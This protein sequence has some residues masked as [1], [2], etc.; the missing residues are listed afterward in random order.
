[1]P[2]KNCFIKIS[3]DMLE[4]HEVFDWIKELSQK[5][6][7]VICVGG[8]TQI[9]EEFE[10]R[11]LEINFG[12]LGRECDNFSQKQ[13]ARDILEINKQEVKNTLADLGV[14]ASVII[15]VV[16]VGTVLCHVNGDQFV[17]LAYHGFDAIFVVT[18]QKRVRDKTIFFAPCNKIKVISF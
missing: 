13:L 5:Y 15:P 7:L 2:R 3:G 1:M 16:E 6:Y 17:L 8:G 9:N 14:F 18:T 4:I 11:G 12:P 10:R